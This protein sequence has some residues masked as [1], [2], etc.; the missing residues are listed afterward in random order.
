MRRALPLLALAAVLLLGA[1]VAGAAAP[2]A[3]SWYALGGSA[4]GPGLSAADVGIASLGRPLSVARG[5]DGR[6][7]VTY[8]D[9]D[10]AVLVKRWTGTAWQAVGGALNE[11]LGTG[12]AD[13][14]GISVS[15]FGAIAPV[16]VTTAA[17]VPSVAWIDLSP[18]VPQ[19]YLRTFIQSAVTLTVVPAGTGTGVV[20]STPSVIQCPDVCAQTLAGGT[21]V[22]LAAI[23]DDGSGFVGWSGG[24][25]GASS[26]SP[27]RSRWTPA[28]RP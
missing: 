7:V 19:A 10:G 9:V 21:V 25:T 11:G 20:T 13:T 15:E 5:P 24:C 23:A 4:S 8:A 12:A 6:P 17:G 26:P 22:T 27:A 16:T 1:T 2:T 14:G 28:P 18:D 3:Q